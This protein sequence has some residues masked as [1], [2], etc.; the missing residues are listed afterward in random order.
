MLLRWTIMLSLLC[1]CSQQ[2]QEIKMPQ[3]AQTH[4]PNDRPVLHAEFLTA[5]DGLEIKASLRNESN[6]DFYIFNHLWSGASGTH[7]P[8]PQKA[9]RFFHHGTLR[10]L[11]GAAPLPR[12]KTVTYRNIPNVSLLRRDT[13]LEWTIKLPNPVK[14]YSIYYTDEQ[15]AVYNL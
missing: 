7:S 1:F 9:Y 4:N 13:L 10:L 3:T 5:R 2:K 15:A 14:E 11:Y 8:D 6:S 12:L